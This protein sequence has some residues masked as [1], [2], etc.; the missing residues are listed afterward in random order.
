MLNYPCVQCDQKI[1]APDSLRGR[2]IPCQNC[3]TINVLERPQTPASSQDTPK[4]PSFSLGPIIH[5]QSASVKSLHDLSDLLLLFAYVLGLLLIGAGF[6]P[7]LLSQGADKYQIF[8][9]IAG[10]LAAIFMFITFKFL[11]GLLQAVSQQIAGQII[12]QEQLKDILM[13][14]REERDL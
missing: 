14:L 7:Y 6:T 8:C 13:L 5:D 3:G 12:V 10:T 9:A 4:T 2:E 1:T 11:S